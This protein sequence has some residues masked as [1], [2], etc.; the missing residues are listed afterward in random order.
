MDCPNGG[1]G[2][3]RGEILGAAGEFEFGD[4]GADAAETMVTWILRAV[5]AATWA[6]KWAMRAVSR[7]PEASERALVPI[8]M[9]TERTPR[10][11]AARST[12]CWACDIEGLFET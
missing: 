8:L 6:A 2:L 11:R 9:T 4:A 10:R 1:G 7:W 12:A 3:E 5:R